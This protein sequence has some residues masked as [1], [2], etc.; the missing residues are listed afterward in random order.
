MNQ[1]GISAT[2]WPT[3]PALDDDDDEFG[4]I[5]GIL[6]EETVVLGENLPQCYFVHYKSHMT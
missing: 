6:T 5:G 2:N 4:A 3:V 1:L